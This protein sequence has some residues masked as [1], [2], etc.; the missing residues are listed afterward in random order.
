MKIAIPIWDN[1]ISP[2]FDTA[3][4]F[5]IIEVEDQ[6]E[7]TRFE[8]I[9]DEQDLSQRCLRIQGLGIDI[10][11]CGAISRPYSWM[12]ISLGINIIPE[13]S[14]QAE[15]VLKAYLQGNLIHS[16]FLMPGCKRHR[17]MKGKKPRRQRRRKKGS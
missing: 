16:K 13:I 15:D 12:L 11:I 9:L 17:L 14:G 5:L 8:T 4:R 7:R 10:I 6:K 3:S 1:R 2:V